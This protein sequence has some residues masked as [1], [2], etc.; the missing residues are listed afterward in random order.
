MSD[1]QKII[2][3]ANQILKKHELCE[4]CL[5]RLFSKK[6]HLSS[7]KLL[8]KKLQKNKNPTKK[9]YI[10]KN[11]FDN[12]NHFLKIMIDVSS[13]YSFQT[14]SVGAILKPSI[15][16]RDDCIRSQFKL[17]GIDSIKTDITKELSK[18]FSKK[19]KHVVDN[20][21]PEFTFTINF[22]DESCKIHSKSITLSGRYIKSMRG[23]S[24]KQKS[25]ENCF[26]KGCRL[27]NFHGISEFDSVEGIISQFIFEK[28]GGTVAKFSW[29]GGE[30]KPSLVLGNGRPFFVK[31]QNPHKRKLRSTSKIFN[32]LKINNLKI[33]SDS[34]K[35]PLKFISS[36]KMKISTES[37]IEIKNLEKLKNLTKSPVVVYDVSGKRSEKKISSVKYK[38]TSQNEFS[39]FLKA[40][41]GLPIKR[42]VNGD[43]VSPGVSS[44]IDN[45]CKCLEFDFLDI[46]V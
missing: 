38:K 37:V 16:D 28:L 26:G 20:R 41:G 10:C 34:P 39:L 7:N 15:I 44:I 2:P 22:K 43:N 46:Q 29:I 40:D 9:C 23:I 30:D 25:C 32:S 6:L 31:L 12:L 36:I 33:V 1:Y 45:S 24:Q 13:D 4:N 5:G 18:A 42:F 8:G 3:I 21:T 11:L 27:C 35:K 19:T 17:R 14:F